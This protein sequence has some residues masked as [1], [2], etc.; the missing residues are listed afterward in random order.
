MLRGAS[1]YDLDVI[2]AVVGHGS[3]QSR[4]KRDAVLGETLERLAVADAILADIAAG[5]LCIATLVG[6]HGG[7]LADFQSAHRINHRSGHYSPLASIM[8]SAK[9]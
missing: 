7:H 9:L 8:A 5:A 1:A 3:G 4:D 2:E 6:W